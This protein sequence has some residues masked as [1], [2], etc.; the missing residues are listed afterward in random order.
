[1]AKS[2]DVLVIGAGLMGAAAAWSLTRRGQ[3]VQL[4]EQFDPQHVHGSSHGSA[5]IL[6]R[7]YGDALYTRLAGQAFE[8]WREIEHSSGATLLHLY[9]GVDFGAQRGVR[10]IARHLA[11]AGVER[12]LLSAADAEARWPGMRFEDEVVFHPLAGTLD[13][14]LAVDAMVGLARASGA[15]VRFSRAVTAIAPSGPSAVVTFDDGTSVTAGVVVVAA[16]GWVTGLLDGLV[17]LPP[18]RVSEQSVFHFPR[19]DPSA[20]PWPSV[21]H[22]ARG[23]ATYHLAGG[24]DGGAGND[25]KIGRHDFGP[26][27]SPDRPLTIDEQVRAELTAYV[28]EWLPGLEPTPRGETTCLYTVTPSE[29]FVLDRVG[30]IVVCSPCSGHGAKF[31]PL[32]GELVADLVAGSAEVPDRFRLSA[33]A[34]GRIGSVSL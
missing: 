10:D 29:D 19:R 7:A 16:G 6:R 28:Q 9:G 12:E 15:D 32:V 26:I 8:L 17:P 21:I 18:M 11:E 2:V 30:P 4:V 13:A 1:M 24:R 22:E 20:T 25:R 33:H 27:V 31:A 3:S 5:R 23:H 34:A 14:A